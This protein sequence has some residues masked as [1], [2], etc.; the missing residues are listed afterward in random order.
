MNP[1]GLVPV[2]VDGDTVVWESHSIVRYLCAARDAGGLWPEDAAER[3]LADRWMDWA[4]A[5]LQ[6]FMTPLF[7]GLVRTPEAGRNRDAIQKAASALRPVWGILDAHLADRDFVAGGRLTMGDIPVGAFYCRYVRL[8]EIARPELPYCNAWLAR[9]SERPAFA[10]HVA[11]V[12]L[13]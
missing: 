6:P 7:W 13:T 12:P 9:L 2:L 5:S 11:G 8:P 10:E 1:N 4:T 3:S